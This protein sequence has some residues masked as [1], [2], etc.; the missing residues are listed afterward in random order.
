M[1]A[2][3]KKLYRV[4]PI[5]ADLIPAALAACD[6]VLFDTLTRCPHCGGSLSAY[7]IRMK[8]FAVVTEG[9]GTRT[10]MVRIRRFRCAACRAVVY[11]PQPFYPDTRAGAPVVDLCIALATLKPY[12]RVS[13]YLRQIGVI[14]DRWSVRN[15]A[16]RGYPA[17]FT[18]DV[19]G[20]PI[21]LSFILLATRSAQAPDG[22]Q[23]SSV[24]ILEA[25]WFRPNATVP[26][27]HSIK[28]LM[29]FFR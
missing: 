13:T 7:D 15:Y 17:P 25:C 20:I 10:I 8:Q 29:D 27:L 21:P 22:H 3:M 14:V 4:L 23:L 2:V 5:L 11:A 24:D 18:V 28:D 6:G 12:A 9:S 1:Q 16:R 26:E 19:S